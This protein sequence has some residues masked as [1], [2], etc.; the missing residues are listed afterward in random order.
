MGEIRVCLAD[1]PTD[2][3][4]YLVDHGSATMAE[5][6]K[7]VAP[8]DTDYPGASVASALD[9]LHKIEYVIYDS[10]D[11]WAPSLAGVAAVRAARVQPVSDTPEEKQ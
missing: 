5:I 1:A 4:V 8:P 11:G 9:L 3:L 6:T 7:A 10:R 2:V